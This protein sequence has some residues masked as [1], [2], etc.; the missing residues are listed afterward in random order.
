MIKFM[1]MEQKLSTSRH[2]IGSEKTVMA[3]AKCA[4]DASNFLET[5]FVLGGPN[6]FPSCCLCT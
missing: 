2:V 3:R 4:G 6:M 5:G 1:D